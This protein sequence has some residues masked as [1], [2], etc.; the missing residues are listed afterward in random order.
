MQDY[1]DFA[2]VSVD[3]M[4]AGCAQE[5]VVDDVEFD[6]HA[7]GLLIAPNDLKKL[8]I[9]D[10]LVCDFVGFVP[11]NNGVNQVQNLVFDFNVD[12]TDNHQTKHALKFLQIIPEKLFI[13]VKI[14]H[15][16]KGMETVH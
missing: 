8:I 9:P 4:K 6:I 11:K 16:F 2:Q 15:H 5:K 14:N 12:F 7:E 13:V 1:H 3:C 10:Q